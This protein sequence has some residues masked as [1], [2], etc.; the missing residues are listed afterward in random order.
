MKQIIPLVLILLVSVVLNIRI[1]KS[2]SQGIKR[3]EPEPRIIY[4]KIFVPKKIF[5]KEPVYIT[6]Y[7]PKKVFIKKPVYITR[8]VPKPVYITKKVFVPKPIYINKK[9]SSFSHPKDSS[10]HEKREKKILGGDPRTWS[11]F[12]L[13]QNQRQNQ[14]SGNQS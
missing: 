6:R 7:V 9:Y 1:T 5:I 12:D 4:K 2:N 10:S 14:N 3:Y 11:P 8:Y 13:D